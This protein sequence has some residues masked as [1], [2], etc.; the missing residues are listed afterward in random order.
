MAPMGWRRQKAIARSAI[1]ARPLRQVAEVSHHLSNLPRPR[2]G[3]ISV[4]VQPAQTSMSGHTRRSSSSCR[5][6]SC[7]NLYGGSLS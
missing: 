6:A 7:S 2:P 3:P 1:P 4:H 5:G